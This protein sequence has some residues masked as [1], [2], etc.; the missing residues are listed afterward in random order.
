MGRCSRALAAAAVSIAALALLASSALAAGDRYEGETS[1]GQ[2]M[3]LHA[4][5]RGA[6]TRAFL[7]WRADCRHGP[8]FRNSTSFEAPLDR[9]GPNRFHDRRRYSVRRG[10]LRARYV[11]E[12]QGVRRTR[13]RLKGTFDLTVR[14]FE[15]GDRYETC[16]VRDVR[17]SAS[18]APR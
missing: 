8:G 10:D 14:F 3:N 2:A 7:F 15:N 6:V 1:Q 5:G 11:A 9:S 12:I 17:W 18:P 13:R 16:T 4:D